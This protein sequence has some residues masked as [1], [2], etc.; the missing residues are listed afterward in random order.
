MTYDCYL[1][2]L[3]LGNDDY[4]I[5]VYAYCQLKEGAVTSAMVLPWFKNFV[6][7]FLMYDYIYYRY[8][9]IEDYTMVSMLTKLRGAD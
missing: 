6:T 9:R 3:W 8:K 7:R 4:R 1:F 2:T 5:N